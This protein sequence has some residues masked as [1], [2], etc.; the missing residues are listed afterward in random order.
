MTLEMRSYPLREC[1]MDTVDGH[2]VLVGHAAVFNQWSV[3]IP[4]GGPRGQFRE[5]VLAGAFNRTLDA[6]PDVKLK[7]DHTGLPLARTISGTLSLTPDDVGL[8]IRAPL[9][10]RDPDVLRLVPK[11]ERGDLRHMSFAFYVPDGGDEWNLT[12]EI[13]ERSLREV[14][15]DTGDVSVVGD[16]A[17]PATDVALRSLTRYLAAA[18]SRSENPDAAETQGRLD[19]LRRRLALVEIDLQ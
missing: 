16:P 3:V 7:V 4:W 1:R 18:E 9:D 14:D 5:R 11:I 2:P 6:K 17:Y 10:E 13:D 15:L 8:A 12:A 19:V